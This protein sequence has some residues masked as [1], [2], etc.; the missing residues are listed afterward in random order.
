MHVQSGTGQSIRAGVGGGGVRTTME[1]QQCTLLS[2]ITLNYIVTFPLIPLRPAFQLNYHPLTG[3]ARPG[4]PSPSPSPC[5]YNTKIPF[6]PCNYL[7]FWRSSF[8][9]YQ[10]Q[11]TLIFDKHFLLEASPLWWLLLNVFARQV[12]MHQRWLS[13]AQRSHDS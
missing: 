3:Q 2:T 7:H 12:P 4:L 9:A 1:W 8:V 10:Q 6:S 5:T 13:R 11:V